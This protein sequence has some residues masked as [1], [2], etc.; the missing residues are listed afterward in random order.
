MDGNIA[1][2]KF[3]DF[4]IKIFKEAAEALA[5]RGYYVFRMGAKVNEKLKSNNKKI[6]DYANSNLRSEFMDIFLGAK[7]NFCISTGHGFDMLPYVFNKHIGI[8]S[9]PVG[10]LRSHSKRFLL[11]T[12]KHYSLNKKKNLSLFEIFDSIVGFAIKQDIFDKEGIDLI[13]YMPEEIKN[14]S[15]EL[16]DYH[17]NKK[18]LSIEEVELQKNSKIIFLI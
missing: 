17:E 6:I 1:H 3:R 5:N 11:L 13:D 7:C 8:M 9:V 4:K 2:N 16:C 14:F 15:L 12:K 10:D 18:E